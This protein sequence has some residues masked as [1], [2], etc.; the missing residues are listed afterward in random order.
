[1]KKILSIL[2]VFATMLSIRVVPV[3]ADSNNYWETY[4]DEPSGIDYEQSGQCGASKIK[5]WDDIDEANYS[6]YLGG[7]GCGYTTEAPE[8]DNRLKTSNLVI[9]DVTNVTAESSNSNFSVE[10]RP[11]DFSQEK[12]Y[13]QEFIK[14]YNNL[15]YDSFPDE[16]KQKYQTKPEWW[17]ANGFE[18]DPKWWGAFGLTS[19]NQAAYEIVIKTKDIGKTTI[20]LK[21]DGK[22][23][24][25]FNL[26]MTID[27]FYGGMKGVKSQGLVHI[28]NNNEKYKEFYTNPIKYYVEENEDLSEIINALKGKDITLDFYSYGD[29]GMDSYLLNG[30]DIKN[31]VGKGFTY[32]HK[33]SM[34]TSI[35]KDKINALV[36][37][38]DAIYIDFTYHGALPAPYSLN[39]DMET[40]LLGQFRDKLSCDSYDIDTN[41]EEYNKCIDN[42]KKELAEYLNNTTFTLL[43]YNPETNQ[44]EVV[45]D[46][47]KAN[48]A[49]KIT[50]D[51]DHF[52]SYVLTSNYEIKP[53]AVANPKTGTSNIILCFVIGGTS[54]VSMLYIIYTYKKKKIA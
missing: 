47:L 36:N 2:L 38:K 53:V 17:Q 5:K 48:S 22:S 18:S 7:G 41:W 33:I 19:E 34:E 20:T 3:R 37:L 54:L 39:V 8:F 42:A 49:G 29:I 15:S 40:Y 52:S 27:N 4:F 9:T 25:K 6:F 43:Y 30:L 12:Q 28:L 1:M 50:L 11:Y 51:F 23:E 46:K 26:N 31:T 21:A 45:K 16:I 24:K 10:I 44:M 35:N 13:F 32:D 14:D